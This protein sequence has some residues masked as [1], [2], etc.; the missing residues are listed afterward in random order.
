M[1]ER[2]VA[3]VRRL[4]HAWVGAALA[5]ALAAPAAAAIPAPRKIARAVS[6][7]NQGSG[8]G[9]PLLLQVSLRVGDAAPS[10][11]GELAA[12]PSGL[13]RLELRS[14]WGFVERHLL[15]SDAYQASRDGELLDDP[16]PFLPP[17]FLLQAGSGEALSAALA[18][19]GVAA[20]EVVFGRLG[21]HDC[22]VLGGRRVGAGPGPELPLASLWVDAQSFE[23][24]RIVRADGVEY[25]FGPLQAFGA[26]RLPRWIELQTPGGL[27]ARLEI[28]GAARAE[29]PAALFQADWL[30][31][32]PAAR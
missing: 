13:A 15:Q 17:V 24:L 9:A 18:S 12:H 22:Y 23:P 3:R 25:R 28:T 4:A 7:A 32:A 27:R 16:H 6:D 2:R 5:L 10:A 11:Q 30:T 21:D 19:F 26:L 29:A 8:R 20:D 31:A 1:N 14:Q